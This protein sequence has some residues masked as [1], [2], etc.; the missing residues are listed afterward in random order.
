MIK[1][2]NQNHVDGKTLD[3][4]HFDLNHLPEF[5]H[6]IDTLETLKVNDNYLQTLPH[7]LGK[8]KNLRVLNCSNNHL[9]L[10]PEGIKVP[11]ANSQHQ[12]NERGYPGLTNLREIYLQK[13]GIEQSVES[14]Q[15]LATLP[16]LN[17]I[18]LK[19]PA[20]SLMGA[21]SRNV[22]STNKSRMSAGGVVSSEDPEGTGELAKKYR[23]EV[24]DYLGFRIAFK[25]SQGALDNP[26]AFARQTLRGSNTN[27][28]S[29][30]QQSTIEQQI[31]EYEDRIRN[32]ETQV[33]NNQTQVATVPRNLNTIPE[34]PNTAISHVSLPQEINP[35]IGLPRQIQQAQRAVLERQTDLD[36]LLNVIDSQAQAIRV[37][38]PEYVIPEIHIPHEI[39]RLID[40]TQFSPLTEVNHNPILEQ[41]QQL[42]RINQ[43]L[44]QTNTFLEKVDG[45]RATQAATLQAYENPANPPQ[46]VEPI[47]QNRAPT[48]ARFTHAAAQPIM[49]A[50]PE[51]SVTDVAEPTANDAQ[52]TIEELMRQLQEANDRAAAAENRAG[53]LTAVQQQ[54][55]NAHVQNQPNL[56][57]QF[58]ALSLR[59]DALIRSLQPVVGNNRR[60]IQLAEIA[61][62]RIDA[63]NPENTQGRL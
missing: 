51:A 9:T 31:R 36:E 38:D 22:Q 56:Q 10:L 48:V 1:V 54:P 50:T 11:N 20:K 61:N 25:R 34:T 33:I 4:S 29:N 55:V 63:M 3:L 27:T 17:Y 13:N 19:E 62:Q 28:T 52:P 58:N 6:E 35:A 60:G 57:Q 7:E 42:R 24:S 53:A 43:Y 23:E 18:V 5:L 59:I 39:S 45:I 14:H 46:P 40:K 12:L 15:I 32:L 44:E 49:L 37:Y 2:K 16:K 41:Q 8:M 30:R 47:I 21:I 26:T